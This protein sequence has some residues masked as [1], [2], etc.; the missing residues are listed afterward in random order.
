MNAVWSW[1]SS[2]SAP[3]QAIGSIISSVFLP[4]TIL[5]TSKSVR[6]A[7]QQTAYA[8]EAM[9]AAKKGA[10][11]SENAANLSIQQLGTSVHHFEKTTKPFVEFK[12]NS[13]CRSAS[14]TNVGGGPALNF[15]LTDRNLPPKVIGYCDTDVLGSG[16][17]TTIRIS[18]TSLRNYQLSIR[19]ESVIRRRH[20]CIVE[21]NAEGE[22]KQWHHEDPHTIDNIFDLTFE[23]N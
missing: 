14:L 7:S 23:T 19:Y 15:L 12:L 11:A 22:Y 16:T 3:L 1:I 2:N 13:D 10:I 4:L 17:T 5:Y 21:W 18:E 20:Y 6:I 9:E 8:K